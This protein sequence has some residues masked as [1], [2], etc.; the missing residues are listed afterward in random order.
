MP[1]QS[2]YTSMCPKQNKTKTFSSSIIYS[3]LQ[4]HNHYKLS[5]QAFNSNLT[6]NM[7]PI[8]QINIPL[9]TWPYTY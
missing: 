4:F 7:E 2:S 3:S 1:P 5:L 9:F 8:P 6:G